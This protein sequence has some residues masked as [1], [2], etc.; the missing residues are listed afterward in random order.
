[1]ATI[2]LSNASLSWV[3]SNGHTYALYKSSKSWV[4]A[5]AY[6]VSVGGYLVN[7][8]DATE[9]TEIFNRVKTA[10]SVSE[11][12]QSTSQ[13]GGGAAYVWLGGNDIQTE[14]SWVWS[15]TSASIS[16]GRTEW[17]TG[18]LW[19]EVVGF[20]AEPDNAGDQDGL[21][22]GLEVW[23][24]GFLSNQGLGNPGQWNDVAISNQ[25][26]FIVEF[27]PTT[28]PPILVT[29]L[30]DAT[31]TEGKLFSYTIPKNTFKAANLKDVITLS[32]T[33]V[34]GSTLPSWLTFDSKK[35]KLTGA[36]NYA[37][38][39]DFEL[40]VTATDKNGAQISDTIF[41]DVTSV[42]EIKGTKKN[43]VI[44]AGA[45]DDWIYGGLGN[46]T[47]TGGS[48]YDYFVFDSKLDGLKNV[49]VITDF[50]TQDTIV[51]SSSIFPKVD[52]TKLDTQLI[53]GTAAIDSDD[54]LICD[55]L[56]GK[57]YYDA[58]G[59]G[60]GAKVHFATLI[61]YNFETIMFAA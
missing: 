45:G 14:G 16:L 13:D 29:P 42:S 48:D 37:V 24:Q 6:A 26:F 28:P 8:S 34:D 9:N 52:V 20:R 43:D 33:M 60:P 4:D 41:I 44:V 46:D 23:P 57:L 22:L 47:L 58:D 1:M 21:A 61:G 56:S 50:D 59:S 12:S 36:I 35:A 2:D 40:K 15:N 39:S 25:L 54:Y 17:G 51:L 5:S 3:S 55:G 53:R 49:D 38:D 10:I 30:L 19:N 7:I 11:F 31:L 32:V 27:D 18:A